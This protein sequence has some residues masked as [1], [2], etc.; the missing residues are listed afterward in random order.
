MSSN[1]RLL[2]ELTLIQM[3]Q[4]TQEED[5]DEGLGPRPCIRLK[6]IF[7]TIVPVAREERPVAATK[8]ISHNV[9]AEPVKEVKTTRSATLL[10]SIGFSFKG[11]REQ[12]ATNT[13]THEASV[14]NPDDDESFTLE[15]AKREWLSIINVM[16]QDK[17]QFALSQRMKNIHLEMEEF[18]YLV[19]VAEN[20]VLYSDIK[21]RQSNF[22]A[23]LARRLKNGH[24]TF[25]IKLEE[26]KT[27]KVLAPISQEEF[28]ESLSK[29][30][31]SFSDM[32]KELQLELE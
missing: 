31:S 10:K 16:K 18:P 13:T 6:H 26:K 21:P 4:I 8:P 24:L 1:K 2:V 20:S 3:A 28:F 15:D 29:E 12:N 22:Q 9:V 7:N 23:E 32:R 17:A 25:E 5:S 11:L 19:G 14:T 27:S 30:E